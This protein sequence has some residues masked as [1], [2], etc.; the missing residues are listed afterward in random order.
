MNARSK[1]KLPNLLCA[2]LTSLLEDVTCKILHPLAW[3]LF[4]SYHFE[5]ESRRLPDKLGASSTSYTVY[6]TRKTFTRSQHTNCP[7]I[8]L[9]AFGPLSGSGLLWQQ[10]RQGRSDALYISHNLNLLLWDPKTFPGQ[11]GYR[12][13]ILAACSASASGT[14]PSW[15]CLESLNRGVQAVFLSDA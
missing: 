4:F 5:Y 3:L 7:S 6:L 2:K 14:C 8:H 10:T 12:Y 9:S 13:V 1:F 15:T 11:M